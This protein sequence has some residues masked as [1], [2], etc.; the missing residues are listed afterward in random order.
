MGREGEAERELKKAKSNG[1]KRG[2]GEKN[3]RD[4]HRYGLT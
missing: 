1:K 4:R 3:K 2:G